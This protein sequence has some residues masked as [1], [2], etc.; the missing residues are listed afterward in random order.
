MLVFKAGC[1]LTRTGQVK[2][3]VH[4]FEV[5]L[6]DFPT[7]NITLTHADGTTERREAR[8]VSSGP[9]CR[10][11]LQFSVEGEKSKQ[12]TIRLKNQFAY[13]A[14]LRASPSPASELSGRSDAACVPVSN[15]VS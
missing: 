2:V 14:F 3:G 8:N 7:K 4:V 1:M 9:L 15:S 5:M 6:E 12:N 13:V 11:K 10:V